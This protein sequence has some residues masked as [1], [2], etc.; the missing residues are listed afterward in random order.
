MAQIPQ[1]WK[2]S[3]ILSQ[4]ERGKYYE[5]SE[6]LSILN[7]IGEIKFY[8]HKKDHV[9]NISCAFDIESSSCVIDTQKVAFMYEWSFCIGGY[10]IIGRK[11]EEFHNMLNDIIEY[12]NLDEHTI[13]PIYVH[14]LAFDFQFLR[15]RFMWATVF[16]LHERKPIKAR[17]LDGIEF[18]C[19]YL[20]SGYSLEKLSDQLL[21]YRI[22]KLK[23]DLDYSKI[24][25]SSTPLTERELQYCIN[26][27]LVVFAYIQEKIE[28]LGNITKITLTKTGVVREYC[29]DE[30][31]YENGKHSKSKKFIEYHKLMKKLTLK[32][33]EY[34]QC[35]D[36]FSGGFTHANAIYTDV[37]IPNVSSYDFTSSYPYV[38]VSEKFPMSKPKLYKIKDYDDFIDKLTIYCCLFELELFDV[39]STFISENYIAKAHCTELEEPVCNNGRIV[40]AKHLC[41]TITERDYFIIYKA[42]KWEDSNVKN[43]RIMIKDYLP[44]DFVKSILKLYHDKTTLKGIKGKEN[45]YLVSKENL[46][47]CYGMSVTDICRDEIIYDDIWSK[48]KPDLSNAIAKYNKSIKRFLYYPWGVWVTAYARSNLWS[49]IF[50]FG[51]DYIYSDTDSIK[52]INTEKHKKYFD[53]YNNNV[54]LKLK[55]AM[56]YHGIPFEMTCPKNNEGVR[57]QLGVWDY[58]GT[59][60]HFK[61]LGAKRYM[62][63]EPD[64]L[65][66]DNGKKYNISITV[67]GVNK[68]SAVPYLVE[69]FKNPFTAFTENLVIPKEHTGK[70]THTYIDEPQSGTLTDYL[71]NEFTFEEYSSIHLEP[72]E[73]S[74]SMTQDYLDYVFQI[75]KE[76]IY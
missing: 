69:K 43:F 6:I 71:G 2:L 4:A 76:R 45:E 57:K 9:L 14:N 65:V 38:M 66:L 24:R 12:Y 58:E 34:V 1:Q 18:R 68:N 50:E 20:L 5:P 62:V 32:P 41:V 23:G 49:G 63:E 21:V 67:A 40:K 25:G 39:E 31:F 42:Y 46:N 47:S 11:W 30:C 44:T 37:V 61:T 51:E 48:E 8:K 27:V 55:N 19:S 56:K 33:E 75:Q 22:H 73:Y 52:V 72:A 53:E 70:L 26:D 59:Y 13:I 28:K 3:Q 15:K 74:L 7:K 64:A 29:R 35:K 36:A 54:I 16:S 60:D 10:V 17:T